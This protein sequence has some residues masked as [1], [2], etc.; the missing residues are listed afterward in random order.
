MEAEVHEITT[1]KTLTLFDK[2]INLEELSE[3]ERASL[4]SIK[5]RLE[6]IRVKNKKQRAIKDF[7]KY[8]DILLEISFLLFILVFVDLDILLK[9]QCCFALNLHHFSLFM[10]WDDPVNH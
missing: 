9:R 5:D 8:I 1:C 2:L 3:D 10:V 7:F 4:S 6:T